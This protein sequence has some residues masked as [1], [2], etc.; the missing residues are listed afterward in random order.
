ML[1]RR[2]FLGKTLVGAAAAAAGPSLW[3]ADRPAWTGPLGL[4]L[5]TVREEFAKDPAATLKKVA[6]VG[7]REVEIGSGLDAA[8][9][10]ADLHAAG[11]TAPSGYFESPA[12]LDEWKKTVEMGH[13]LGLHYI[14]VGDN[15]VLTAEEWKRRADLYNQC[16]KAARGA[17][18]QFCYHAHFHEFAPV[19]STT[20]YDI[21]LKECDP[22][23]LKMEMDIFW[24]IYAGQDPI[25]YFRKYPGR[26]PLLHIKDMKKDAKGSTSD[27]PSD[28]GP[29]PFAPV[30]EGK[31]DWAGIFA[32]AHEAGAKH[33][34]VE[35]DRCDVSPFEAIKISYDYVKKLRLS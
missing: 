10:K 2:D 32:H 17:G 21:M 11:L 12:T 4:E 24:A 1:T 7:Y 6:A 18:M 20:G 19:D 33:I 26:F 29:N 8:K 13:G 5:Y 15:P 3:A 35:Q 31:I 25:A 14:V 16:G 28:S 34:F 30:G 27:G 22:K 23:L 9:V